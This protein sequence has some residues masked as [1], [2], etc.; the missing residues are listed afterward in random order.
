MQSTVIS[1]Q[2]G[3]R[4]TTTSYL[5]FEDPSMIESTRERKI[6][7]FF[8]FF[9]RKKNSQEVLRENYNLMGIP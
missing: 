9:A 2:I 3:T 6:N 5:F 1:I 4:R 8:C 7:I